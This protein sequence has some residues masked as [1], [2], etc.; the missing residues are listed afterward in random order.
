[1]ST[2]KRS[3]L[4]RS[5]PRRSSLTG[6]S[7]LRRSLFR[8]AIRDFLACARITWGGKIHKRKSL[9]GH[10]TELDPVVSVVRAARDLEPTVAGKKAHVYAVKTGRLSGAFGAHGVLVGDVGSR[11]PVLRGKTP[12]ERHVVAVEALTAVEMDEDFI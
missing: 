1:M 3:C 12:L 6:W 7:F 2:N 5:E 4:R 10:S 8:L 9:D 11:G